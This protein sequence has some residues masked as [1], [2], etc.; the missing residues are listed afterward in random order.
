MAPDERNT[1]GAPFVAKMSF[2]TGDRGN[3]AFPSLKT[4]L[5]PFGEDFEMIV[6]AGLF[7]QSRK[8]GEITFLVLHR[9]VLSAARSAPIRI[10]TLVT[11]VSAESALAMST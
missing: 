11:P 1:A 5:S 7:Q 9:H 10:S 6:N 2:P 8:K 3:P 4:I